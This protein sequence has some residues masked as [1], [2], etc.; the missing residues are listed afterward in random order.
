MSVLFF[1]MSVLVLCAAPFANAQGRVAADVPGWVRSH[2]EAQ[3]EVLAGLIGLPRT[4]FVD[5]S[6]SGP[7]QE[8]GLRTVQGR[9]QPERFSIDLSGAW[10][11][12]H[13]DA[14][15][16][17]TRNVAHETAH[18]F[19]Y[20]LGEPIESRMLH[21]GFAE[22]MAV[23]ALMACGESCAGN[24]KGLELKLRRQCGD[25]LRSGIV[26]TLNTVDS[27]YGCGGV[28][29]L[30]GARAAEISVTDLY[31]LFAAA[32]RTE[33]ALLG[34]LEE[35]AGSGFAIS[36]KAFLYSDYRLAKPAQVFERLREGRL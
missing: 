15:R 34:V 31:R 27:S 5:I 1:A 4:P 29:T 23:E 12:Q 18:V 20:S 35:K 8:L 26:G 16:Q 14:R 13:A 9:A 21:E 19:Q 33:K 2:I 30:E 22:A 36:A 25:A 3:V 24:G 17:L 11:E 32:G 6:Y 28:L 7:S 10:Q